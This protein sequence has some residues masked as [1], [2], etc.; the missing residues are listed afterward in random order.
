MKKQ[1][2]KNLIRI[3][4]ALAIVLVA[5]F[6]FR[7]SIYRIAISYKDD[8]G[9][10][11]YKVKDQVLSICIED[12]IDGGN[13][14]NIDAIV[15][16]T[17]SITADALDFSL[18]SKEN[19]PNKT[20]LLRQANSVGYAA[21]AA[22]TGNYL[23]DKCKLSKL[24][25]AEPVKGKLFLFGTDMHKKTKDNFYKDHDFV[26]FRNKVTSKEICIDPALFDK[27]G[28]ERISKY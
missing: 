8:G 9:R 21:F 18:E 20:V 17:Q 11:D 4:F 25:E 14:N 2:K 15:T 27:W 22:A 26:I 16:L 12:H 23:I 6:V 24:W 19:D 5:G 28:I 7:G 13:L 10:K 3:F 1:T